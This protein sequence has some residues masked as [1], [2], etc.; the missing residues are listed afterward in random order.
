M[1]RSFS[2][3]KG[4]KKRQRNEKSESISVSRILNYSLPRNTKK[5]FYQYEATFG[6]GLLLLLSI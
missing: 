2:D 6:F 5:S 4:I 3:I 1:N